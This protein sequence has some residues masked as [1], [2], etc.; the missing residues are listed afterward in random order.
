MFE[1]LLWLTG[2]IVLLGMIVAFDGSKDVFHPLVF[3]GPMLI[4]LYFWMPSRLLA[5][6]GLSRFFLDEQ[7]IFV[8]KL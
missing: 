3:I 5:G 8:Q 7:L 4:F 1:T 2:G 6:D